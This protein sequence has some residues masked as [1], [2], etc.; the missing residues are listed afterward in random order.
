M[1][2]IQF[3]SK[4]HGPY[5]IKYDASYELQSTA[6]SH[7]NVSVKHSY[8]NTMCQCLKQ[9]LMHITNTKRK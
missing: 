6:V 8:I 3:H 9:H 7:I 5:N 1:V 2:I 4:M